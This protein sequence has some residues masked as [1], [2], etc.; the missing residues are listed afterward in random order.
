MNKRLACLLLSLGAVAPAL[1]ADW[2]PDAAF[3]QL[4][5]GQDS[6]TTA[7]VG[8]VW[9]WSWQREAWGG[10]LSG[11]TELYASHWRV[12]DFG[13]GKQTFWQLGLVPYVRYNFAGGPWFAELG[14]GASVTDRLYKTPDKEFSTRFNFSDN[15]A[16]GRTFG[17][18]NRQEISL[19]LQH[20]SN[21]GIKKPNPGEEFVQLRYRFGF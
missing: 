1:A 9:P 3:V 13:G 21:A 5:G 12:E 8:V 6:E 16:V 15:L 4:G 18:D 20:I 19:R 10:R 2:R 17:A 7:T 14:I 11:F